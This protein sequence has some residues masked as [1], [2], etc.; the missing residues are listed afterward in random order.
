MD[1]HVSQRKQAE[2]ETNVQRTLSEKTLKQSFE[3]PRETI[4]ADCMREPYYTYSSE[5]SDFPI[6]REPTVRAHF[7]VGAKTQAVFSGL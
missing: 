1:S 5:H 4:M 2:L 3:T 7:V 6:S